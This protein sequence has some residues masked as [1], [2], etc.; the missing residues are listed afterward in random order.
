LG[1]SNTSKIEKNFDSYGLLSTDPAR[2]PVFHDW[3]KV[4]AFYCDGSEYTGSKNDPVS[5]KDQSLYFRGYN[6]VLEM[7]HYLDQ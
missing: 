2:N 3:T 1:S 7:F 6:N 4:W 5:Y